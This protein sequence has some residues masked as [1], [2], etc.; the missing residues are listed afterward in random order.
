MNMP[1]DGPELEQSIMDRRHF[2]TL[3]T[4][5][6][7]AGFA[8]TALAAWPERMVRLVVPFPPAGAIDV[9][10]RLIVNRLQEAWG[11][12]VIIENKPGAGGN[13]GNELVAR[14]EPNGYTIL[15]TQS[16]IVVNRF[17]Y[18]S[19]GYDPVADLAPVSL[20]A[21]VPNVMVVPQ[22]SPA[23]TVGELIAYAGTRPLTF[24]SA[25]NGTSSHMCGELFKR[26]A[27]IELTH[28][29]YRGSALVLSDL[30]AGRLDVTIDSVSGLLPHI[31][32]G[33]LRA[34]GVTAGRPLAILPELRPLAE[35]GL[36]GFEA[37]GLVAALA[38]ARTPPDVIARI[39][40]DL[41]TVLLEP[42]IKQRLEELGDEVVA[43]TPDELARYIKSEMDK[44]GPLIREARIRLDG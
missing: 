18:P 27:G 23:R 6:A 25:G 26:R 33:A 19:L 7:V 42:A 20:L 5:G 1:A 39:Q 29:P 17:L 10:A 12:Q 14:A 30:I 21:L 40:K 3:A 38:P 13:I 9:V 44:W 37:A 8:G 31:R 22:S 16:G 34:L 35:L 32:A 36:P 11:Q 15:L 43:S 24:G 2:L 28:V 41:A 4:S